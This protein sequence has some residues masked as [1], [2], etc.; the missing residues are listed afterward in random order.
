[1]AQTVHRSNPTQALMQLD[2]SFSPCFHNADL[3][4]G[5][6]GVFQISHENSET[7]SNGPDD[8]SP[9]AEVISS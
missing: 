8:K 2:E 6:L 5:P 1:M 7:I 4:K 3:W 9:N